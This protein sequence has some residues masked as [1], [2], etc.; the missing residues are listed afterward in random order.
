[1]NILDNY[2]HRAGNL[3]S[4]ETVEKVDF[5]AYFSQWEKSL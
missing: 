3:H 4:Q 1:M 2:L 5:P